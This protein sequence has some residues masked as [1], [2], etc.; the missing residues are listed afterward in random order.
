MPFNVS[1]WFYSPGAI[2]RL[3]F[4]RERKVKAEEIHEDEYPVIDLTLEENDKMET[5]D[6][7]SQMRNGADLTATQAQHGSQELLKNEDDV[8]VL[9]L[10]EED[11]E[12]QLP[13]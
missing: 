4:K 11:Q 13:D 9:I 10:M 5:E 1:I 7:S 3:R 8:E 6:E 2:P 12:L